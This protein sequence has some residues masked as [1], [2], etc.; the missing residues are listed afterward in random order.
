MTTYVILL[1]GNEDTWAS[2]TEEERAATYA[3][4]GEFAR[5]LG[6]RGHT[7][8]GGAELTHSRESRVVRAGGEVTDGPYAETVEQLTGFYVVETDDLDDLLAVC[9][10]LAG[11]EGAVEVRAA[12]G[13]A[14]GPTS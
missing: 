14:E 6:E 12:M 5:M 11:A 1:P 10:F 2:A 13:D 8:T 9:G 7:I 4:H 3:H